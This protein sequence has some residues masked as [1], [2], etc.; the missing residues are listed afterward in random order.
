M[1][2]TSKIT[3]LFRTSKSK[4]PQVNYP[5]VLDSIQFEARKL[6]E[7]SLRS[8]DRLRWK[9]T[10]DDTS[11]WGLVI[12]LWHQHAT[13]CSCSSEKSNSECM[14]APLNSQHHS[15]GGGAARTPVPIYYVEVNG[16]GSQKKGFATLKSKLTSVHIFLI[17]RFV[18][19]GFCKSWLWYFPEHEPGVW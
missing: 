6:G 3:Y 1:K 4:F 7:W 16:E 8:L 17:L 18:C 19:K 12:F 2:G 13:W 14:R 11:I 9:Q 15:G 5:F 10:C